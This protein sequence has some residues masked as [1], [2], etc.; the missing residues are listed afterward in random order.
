[1]RISDWSSDVC[2]SDLVGYGLSMSDVNAA[3]NQQN[4]LISG[5]ILGSPPN[6]DGQRV[7]APIVVNGQLAT[8][9]NFGKIVL[10]SNTDGSSVRLSDVAR[11]EVG[12]DNYQIGARLNGKPTA[13]SE[14]PTSELQSLM[15]IQSADF[16]L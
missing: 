15:R 4:V 7:T 13:R 9:K 8:V 1:M 6:P 5:G 12:A 16:C 10:R 11:I 14:E 2:S 3:I